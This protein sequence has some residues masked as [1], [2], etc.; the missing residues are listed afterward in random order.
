MEEHESRKSLLQEH[1]QVYVC[2]CV[3][4]FY[5]G[6]VKTVAFI[7]KLSPDMLGALRDECSSVSVK[8]K[9]LSRHC[10]KLTG[11]NRLFLLI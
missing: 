7:F 1:V 8:A 4:E 10:Q 3:Y 11:R 9:S 6:A 2:V 5:A